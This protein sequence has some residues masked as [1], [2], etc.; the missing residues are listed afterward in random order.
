MP[1]PLLVVTV[2]ATRHGA[3]RELEDDYLDR[4]RRVLPID[5]AHVEPSRARR[6]PDRRAEEAKGIASALAPAA[7]IVP[8]DEHGATLSSADFAAKLA[9]WRERGRVAFVVGGPDGL[10]PSLL[11]RPAEP[12]SLGPMTLPHELALVV[13]LEQVYRALLA[14]RNH[15][16]AR[17]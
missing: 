9:R 13:A 7:V 12:L 17:H 15:P 2:G 1:A 6:A 10:D 3:L 11:E 14:A 8:L 16:Y 5:R 4:V